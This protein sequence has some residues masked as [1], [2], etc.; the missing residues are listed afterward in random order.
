MRQNPNPLLNLNYTIINILYKTKEWIIYIHALNETVIK[1][2]FNGWLARTPW[3]CWWSRGTGERQP[4]S[5]NKGSDCGQSVQQAGLTGLWEGRNSIWSWQLWGVGI[6]LHLNHCL[7]FPV[8]QELH[9]KWTRVIHT[10][11]L[12]ADTHGCDP[13]VNSPPW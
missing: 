12:D 6:P 4:S 10:H 9:R 8:W 5:K 3:F 2:L 1:K 7:L 13:Q 11:E